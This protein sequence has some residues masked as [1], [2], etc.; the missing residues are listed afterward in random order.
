[1][2]IKT[3]K[4]MVSRTVQIERFEPVQVTFEAAATIEEDEDIDKAQFE[5]YKQVTQF[6]KKCVDNEVRKYKKAKE[7]DDD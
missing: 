3:I 7:N 1:M 4:V 5:L 2:K 6:T